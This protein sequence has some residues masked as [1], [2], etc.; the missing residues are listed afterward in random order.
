MACK[1]TCLESQAKY[2]AKARNDSKITVNN[3][4]GL[5]THSIRPMTLPRAESSF[6]GAEGAAA[7][8]TGAAKVTLTWLAGAA[9]GLDLLTGATLA[10]AL[11]TGAFVISSPKK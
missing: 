2:P 10:A 5:S 3:L 7:G 1:I 11:L 8:A 9:F 6:L 4:N